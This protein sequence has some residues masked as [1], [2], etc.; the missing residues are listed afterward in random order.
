M[1]VLADDDRQQQSLVIASLTGYRREI[2]IFDDGLAARE[3]I[4]AAPGLALLVCSSSLPGLDGL[5]LTRH[6]RGHPVHRR[7]PV[8]VTCLGR[9]E[10][11][12]AACRAAGADCCLPAPLDLTRLRYEA[13]MLMRSRS[14][15][16]R[17]VPTPRGP[18][19]RPRT[20]SG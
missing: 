14:E 20:P 5:G 18:A 16:S 17:D 10:G 2:H 4:D 8:I 1:I 19:T 6:V 9:D 3:A 15:V 7:S 13:E 12:V 11:L